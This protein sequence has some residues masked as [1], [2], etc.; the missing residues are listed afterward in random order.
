MMI[1]SSHI[2]E[3]VKF[4]IDP[5]ILPENMTRDGAYCFIGRLK[6]VDNNVALL[7]PV[8]VYR[9]EA[10]YDFSITPRAIISYLVAILAMYLRKINI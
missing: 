10:K 3:F 4:I 6:K 9:P 2:G 7:S 1:L 8:D 5:R